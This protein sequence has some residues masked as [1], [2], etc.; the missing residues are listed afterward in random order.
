MQYLI[1]FLEG[2]VSFVSPCMLPLLPVYLS[3]F[4][5]D[6]G[7]DARRAVPVRAA[8]FCAGFTLVFCLMGLLSGTLGQLLNRYRAAVNAVCGIAVMLFGLGYL[9]ILPMN[10]LKGMRGPR[11]AGSIAQAFT[12]GIVYS[13][14]L[15]LC[16]GAFLGSALM[17][18]ATSAGAVK[19][20]TLLLA[21]SLGLAVPFVLSALVL[22]RLK[23]AF[24]MIKR[25]YRVLNTV[26]GVLLILMG[27]FMA[28]GGADRL[29]NLG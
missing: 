2:I 4:A 26:C 18:A 13:V 1:T 6:R 25:H 27:L 21:Y 7:E 12:F 15:T 9:E 14:S 19:G 24:A 22:D 28:L 3:Y 20:L 23:G 17:L 5:G 29:M 11:K 8:A 16:V 10:F